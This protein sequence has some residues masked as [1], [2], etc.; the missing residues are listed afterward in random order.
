MHITDKQ[1]VIVVFES[2]E[3][4]VAVVPTFSA[5]SLCKVA[6]WVFFSRKFKKNAVDESKL[7]VCFKICNDCRQNH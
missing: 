5:T 3:Q 7:V 2:T 4:L 6:E 1:S